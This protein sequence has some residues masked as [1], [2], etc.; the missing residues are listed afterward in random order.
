VSLKDGRGQPYLEHLSI[1]TLQRFDLTWQGSAT[2]P[3]IAGGA[4]VSENFESPLRTPKRLNPERAKNAMVTYVSRQTVM[5]IP[6]GGGPHRAPILGPLSTPK[7]FD[8]KRPNL[9]HQH[10][11]RRSVFL[12]SESAMRQSIGGGAPASPNV[13]GPPLRTP[14]RPNLV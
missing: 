1:I 5:P 10:M 13:L 11:W 14:K 3:S 8:L 9:V 7:Q 4:L 12:Y 6:R 2:S